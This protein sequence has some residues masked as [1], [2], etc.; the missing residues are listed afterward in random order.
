MTYDDAG[1]RTSMIA[2]NRDVPEYSGTYT[3][4]YGDHGALV[5]EKLTQGNEDEIVVFD[6]TFGYD[7]ANQ[8]LSAM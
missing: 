4:T 1:K 3:W 8:L 6:H 2:E 5:E 7:D